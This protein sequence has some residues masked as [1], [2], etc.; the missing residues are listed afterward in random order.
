MNLYLFQLGAKARS[1]FANYNQPDIDLLANVGE[2]KQALANKLISYE[3]LNASEECFKIVLEDINDHICNIAEKFFIN[4]GV[5]PDD[6]ISLRAYLNDPSIVD[7]DCE[8]IKSALTNGVVNA[9]TIITICNSHREHL[10]DKE[11]VQ[12]YFKT[13]D[14]SICPD[15]KDD[16]YRSLHYHNYFEPHSAIPNDLIIPAKP[17]DKIECLCSQLSPDIRA[18]LDWLYQE[19][20]NLFYDLFENIP[21]DFLEDPSGEHLEKISLILE[22]Q[23]LQPELAS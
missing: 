19:D 1:V 9:K 22:S 14:Q 8:L 12:V 21:L 7:D 23:L 18:I 16:I 13:L 10:I 17:C 6:E 3:D 2:I 20:P 5:Y 4:N 15:E 11:T